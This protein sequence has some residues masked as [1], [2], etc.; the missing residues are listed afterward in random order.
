MVVVVVVGGGLEVE[1]L[2]RTVGLRL[3]QHGI[4]LNGS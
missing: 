1:Y 3:D 2:C 4:L